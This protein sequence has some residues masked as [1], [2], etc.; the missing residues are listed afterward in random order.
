MT[1]DG[2][3][4]FELADAVARKLKNQDAG[5][6]SAQPTHRSRPVAPG[7]GIAR[8]A[9]Q[10]GFERRAGWTACWQAQP[11][12]NSALRAMLRAVRKKRYDV[13][14]D[15]RLQSTQDRIACTAGPRISCGPHRKV[16]SALRG[17][18]K[19]LS[20]SIMVCQLAALTAWSQKL[21]SGRE[22]F[23]F[24]SMFSFGASFGPHLC[25]I[26][27]CICRSSRSCEF[28]ELSGTDRF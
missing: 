14:P 3:R 8:T 2:P 9:L 12:C 24:E 27:T 18:A 11:A 19:E 17:L 4:T 15:M 7:P 16:L 21:R 5:D 28:V 13:E 22:P 20:R 23:L 1:Q 10:K 6:R 25:C 26:A